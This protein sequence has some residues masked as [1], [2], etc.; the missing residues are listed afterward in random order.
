MVDVAGAVRASRRLPAARRARAWQDA[1]RRAGGATR[2]ADLTQI[3]LAAKLEDG[4]QV[5]V[6]VR[7]RR[8]AAARRG[9]GA[10]RVRRPA[11]RR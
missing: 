11:A 7:R 4:R 10:A 2:R 9:A 1:L 3:N 8:A 6:P 5:L